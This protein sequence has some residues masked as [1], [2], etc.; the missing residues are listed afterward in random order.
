MKNTGLLI[1]FL[2]GCFIANGQ[3]VINSSTFPKAGDK[4]KYAVI[5]NPDFE[6]DL[7]SPAGPRTWDFSVLNR[8][9][10]YEESYV[11]LNEGSNPDVFPDAD[12]VLINDRQETYIK[13][14]DTKLEALGL[15][16][17][18]PIF[19]APLAIRYTTNPYLRQAPLEFVGSTRSESKF[20][21]SLD[22]SVFPDSLLAGIPANFKPDSIRVEFSSSEKGI[23]DAYGTL[24][25]QDETFDVLREKVEVESTTSVFMKVSI[26][27]WVNLETISGLI[28][29]PPFITQ[30]LGKR[31]SIVYRFHSN[32]KKEILVSASYSL[33]NELLQVDFADLGKVTATENV[34]IQSI[35]CYPNPA[36]HI[37]NIPTD[38]IPGGMYLVTLTD[39]SGKVVHAAFDMIQ[40]GETESMDVSKYVTGTYFLT[41]RSQDNHFVATSKVLIAK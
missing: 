20:R 4:L 17:I 15:G 21:I 39:Y 1:V 31:E 12:L 24:N 30:F 25:M 37:L 28:T 22:A 6:L 27:G 35:N 29:L 40:N 8:G 32:D 7:K 13:S 26:L 19:N 23:M 33:D 10:K 16:G 36:N 14:N 2:L 9:V 3:A 38:V 18:N 11:A 5:T 34:Q 41:L